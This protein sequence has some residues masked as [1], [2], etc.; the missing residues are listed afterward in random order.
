MTRCL[1]QLA[2]LMRLICNNKG[3]GSFVLM[4]VAMPIFSLLPHGRGQGIV[5]T[6]RMCPS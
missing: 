5:F 3:N 4:S 1:F 6:K 2:G